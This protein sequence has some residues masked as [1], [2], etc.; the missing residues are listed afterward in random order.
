M[1]WRKQTV[2]GKGGSIT[3]EIS[4]QGMTI[5]ESTVSGWNTGCAEL[6]AP[7]WESLCRRLLREAYLMVDETPIK[8]LDQQK[9]KTTHRGQYWVYY[10]PRSGLVVFDYHKGRGA[11][12]PRTFLADFEGVAQTDG[13]AGYHGLDNHPKILHAGCM[14]HARRKFF[15]ARQAGHT[16][17]V[18]Q[19]MNTFG[20]LYA[21]EADLRE[22]QCDAAQILEARH[23]SRRI[24]Q[25]F[26]HWLEEHRSK[27]L[28]KSPLGKA[29]EYTLGQLKAP[30]IV[31]H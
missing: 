26:R 30:L 6:V 5:A 28:P 22:R 1:N 12:V 16:E 4:S 2:A 17:W 9:N 27:V 11:E 25:E 14:A 20:Q 19:A 7:L 31:P 8:V 15:E 13:Y 23:Q 24:L 21:M 29:I 10:A 3:T 18:D